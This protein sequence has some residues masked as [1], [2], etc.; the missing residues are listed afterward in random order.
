MQTLP[1]GHCVLTLG[2]DMKVDSD[3]IFERWGRRL[4]KEHNYAIVG[5]L[6]A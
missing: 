2:T 5:A 6:F 4:L 3:L 1:I